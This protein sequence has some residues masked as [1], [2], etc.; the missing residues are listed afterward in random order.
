MG[1]AVAASH[2]LTRFIESHPINRIRRRTLL[3]PL[4]RSVI[5]QNNVA[6]IPLL[7]AAADGSVRVLLITSRSS[8]SWT[9]PKGKVESGVKPID[10]VKSEA[11][12]EAGVL[13]SVS[14]TPIG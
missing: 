5:S 9:I 14:A 2:G 4:R 6:A 3:V 10:T 1:A 13:G 12:E 7:P 8:G 11:F